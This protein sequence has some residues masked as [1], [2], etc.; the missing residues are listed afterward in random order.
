MSGESQF[1]THPQ[2]RTF[3]PSK[4]DV[5]QSERHAQAAHALLVRSHAHLVVRAQTCSTSSV[6]R[7]RQKRHAADDPNAAPLLRASCRSP[8]CVFACA[9]QGL[10]RAPR[11]HP[12]LSRFTMPARTRTPAH[13]PAT[14][15]ARP[16]SPTVALVCARADAYVGQNTSARRPRD[17]LPP[18]CSS[19][20]LTTNTPT[21]TTR[22]PAPRLR[23]QRSATPSTTS[24]SSPPRAGR[25]ASA[26]PFS[27]SPARCA[28]RRRTGSLPPHLAHASH[29][30]VGRSSSGMRFASTC[31]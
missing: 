18:P 20:I 27:R 15:H 22:A 26:C 10:Q 21:P 30:L 31:A 13:A 17:R 7:Y 2:P 12:P 25:R 6:R 8:S 16:D 29:V 14:R 5:L 24:S 1:N 28:P 19:P 3:A 23:A 4:E 9:A 11:R